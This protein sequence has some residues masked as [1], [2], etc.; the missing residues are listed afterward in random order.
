M[1]MWDWSIGSPAMKRWYWK[2][3]RVWSPFRKCERSYKFLFL[4]E[5]YYGRLVTDW[6]YDRDMWLSAEEFMLATL[7]DE[8]NE[9]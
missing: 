1:V 2:K 7:K 6:E 3:R 5:A 9:C 8:F 4:K